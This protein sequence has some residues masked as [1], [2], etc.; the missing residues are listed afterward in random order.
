MGSGGEQKWCSPGEEEDAAQLAQQL[1]IEE[2]EKKRVAFPPQK[3]DRASERQSAKHKR[4]RA[5]TR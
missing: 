4:G 2:E 5:R 3:A 1:V